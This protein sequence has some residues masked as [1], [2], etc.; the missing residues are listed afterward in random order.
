MPVVRRG[1]AAKQRGGGKR[2]STP[3]N[4][5]FARPEEGADSKC[6]RKGEK[7]P[8][9]PSGKKKDFDELCGTPLK[10]KKKF[11]SAANAPPSL[12]HDPVGPTLT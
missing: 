7:G 10:K 4:R 9:G 8:P 6:P 12:A 1:K 3:K 5:L 11:S 2:K